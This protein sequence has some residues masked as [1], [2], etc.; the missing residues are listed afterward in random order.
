MIQFHPKPLLPQFPLVQADINPILRRISPE[1]G[2][3]RTRTQDRP[4]TRLVSHPAVPGLL[5]MAA[6]AAAM[7]MANSGLAPS[8][9]AFLD[10]V[11]MVKLD[12]VG[13]ER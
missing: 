9:Q 8:Y 7:V 3:L 10:R 1:N 13:V 6:A 5:L 11:L 12:G 2:T 4:L